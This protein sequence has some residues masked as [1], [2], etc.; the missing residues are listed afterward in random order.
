VLWAALGLLGGLVIGAGLM[1]LAVRKFIILVY[2][3][4]WLPAIRSRRA[5]RKMSGRSDRTG[6]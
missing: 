5:R 1:Y 2:P 4:A 6:S 3:S